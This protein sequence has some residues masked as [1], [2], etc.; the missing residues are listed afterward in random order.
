LGIDED[1]VT[2]VNRWTERPDLFD[3]RERLALDYA[4]AITLTDR[5]V[6]D[7]LFE[8]LREFF[9]DDA[10]VELTEL[11]AWENASSKFNRALR[12]GSQH[13]FRP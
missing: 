7:A 1:K 11:I 6:G 8:R 4:D 3:E 5:D 2:W 9:D 10:I 12:I 13:L